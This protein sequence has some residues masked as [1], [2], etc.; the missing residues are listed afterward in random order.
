M[1]RYAIVK[2]ALITHVL[3]SFKADVASYYEYNYFLHTFG[4]SHQFAN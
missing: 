1:Q 4:A 3:P 2:D